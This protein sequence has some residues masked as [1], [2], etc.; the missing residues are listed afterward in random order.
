[1]LPPTEIARTTDGRDLAICEWGS[2]AGRPVFFLHGM[3]G[4][5]YFR[6][7][8]GEYDRIGMRLITFDRPGYG[9][10]TRHPGRT[11]ADG[12]GDVAAVADH[13]GVDR[14][15][16]LGASGG[17]PYALATA[18]VMHDR[19][20]RCATVVGSGPHDA[21]DL[22]AYAGRTPEDVEEWRKVPTGEW[23]EGPY[24]Q[25]TRDWVERVPDMTELPQ[26]DR[27]MVVESLRAGLEAGPYG[28]FDDLFAE[29]APWGFDLGDVLCPTK[30]MIAR[31]DVNVPPAHG[32][33]L[34]AHLPTAEAVW[35][36]GNH[37]GP[38]DEPEEKL[39][40]WLAGADE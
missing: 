2:P 22:D 27:D 6:H 5:R 24:Y 4:G 16:V 30:V 10:S 28:L 12:A 18:A 8:G 36:D 9:K 26:Q 11:V 3:P 21:P 37:F 33:W 14:F 15:A 19:V 13:L 17:G 32:E 25:E 35:V 34:V 23:L 1:M 40:A 20:T 39:L 38:R 29:Q 31:E 7:A